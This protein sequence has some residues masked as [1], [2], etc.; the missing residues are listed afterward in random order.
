MERTTFYF[1]SALL[2]VKYVWKIMLQEKTYKNVIKNGDL[3][4]LLGLRIPS[5]CET[6]DRLW[7]SERQDGA[8]K[9][10]KRGDSRPAPSFQEESL[11]NLER[12][13]KV[14]NLSQQRKKN[15]NGIQGLKQKQSVLMTGALSRL[16]V[17]GQNPASG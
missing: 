7:E 1:P 15:K 10:A 11:K 3:R 8:E 2:H 17:L 4:G 5:F 13:P 16:T 14:S 9:R 6:K 12:S